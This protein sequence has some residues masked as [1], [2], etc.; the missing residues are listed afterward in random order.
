MRGMRISL[1]HVLMPVIL[2]LCVCLSGCKSIGYSFWEKLGYE[3]RDLLVGEI[4]DARDSQADAKEDF[5][6][7]L[8]R[9]LELNGSESSELEK[10]YR[11]LNTSYEKAEASAEDVRD[12]IAEVEEVASD[13]FKEWEAEIE[14]YQDAELKRSSRSTLKDTKDRYQQLIVSMNGAADSM[15]PVLATLKDQ[16]LFLK[17]NLNA[18]AIANLDATAARVQAD[19]TALIAEMNASIA[20]AESFIGQMKN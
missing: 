20:E 15:D 19:V 14:E 2:G 12:D 5:Q 3:K 9:L 17:H 11:K 8:D 4:E 16:V 7:A 10:V 13:L 6:S 18:Q 1:P